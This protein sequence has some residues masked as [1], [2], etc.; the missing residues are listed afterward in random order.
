MEMKQKKPCISGDKNVSGE[1][2]NKF[3]GVSIAVWKIER[4]ESL[5]TNSEYDTVGKI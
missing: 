2:T 3:G 4:E 5:G 1:Q